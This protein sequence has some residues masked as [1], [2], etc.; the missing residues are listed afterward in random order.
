M[1]ATSHRP[2]RGAAGRA[3]RWLCYRR[4]RGVLL[5]ATSSAVVLTGFSRTSPSSA[6]NVDAAFA[7]HLSPQVDVVSSEV[8]WLDAYRGPIRAR[9]V[10]FVGSTGRPGEE[11]SA[12]SD[13]YYAEVRATSEAAVTGPTVLS[14]SS[15]RNLTRTSG[16]S[17]EQLLRQGRHVAYASK[18]GDTY[19]AVGVLD[20]RGERRTAT[21][22][23]PLRAKIQNALSNL[24]DTG[25]LRGFARTRFALRKPAQQLALETRESTVV[26]RV[27][28]AEV[29]L[30]V[31]SRKSGRPEVKRAQS[32]RFEIRPAHKAQPGTLTWVVDTVRKLSFV[33][34]EPIAWLEHRV[35]ALKDWIDRRWYNVVGTDTEA[36]VAKDFGVSQAETRRRAEFSVPDPEIGWPPPALEPIVKRAAK[37]EGEWIAVVQDPFVASY[38][39]APPAFYQSFLQVD[40]ERPFTRVYVVIWDPRQVQFRVMTGTRE[41][42]SATGETGPGMVPRDKDTMR[43]VVAGFNGGFQSLHGEFG[44]MSEGRVYLPPKPW[45]ATVAVFRDGRVGMGSWMD[46]PE[47]VRRYQEE[48][49]TA[50]IPKN[51]VELRQNLTSVVEGDRYN[52]WRRWWWGAAPAEAEEQAYIDRS[53]VCLTKAGHMAYFWGKSMGADELGSAM[54]AT[55]CVRGVHLDM[56]QRHTGFE[57]YNVGYEAKPLPPLDRRLRATEFD[58]PMPRASSFRVRGRKLVRA[59][60]P[61]RFPRYIRRDPRDFFYLTLKPVLPGPHLGDGRPGAP[62]TFDTSGL[63]HAGWPH[64]FARTHLGEKKGAR[65]WLVRID[66]KRT[67]PSAMMNAESSDEPQGSGEQPSKEPRILAWLSAPESPAADHAVYAVR[68]TVGWRLRVGAP[69]KSAVVIAKGTELSSSS[70]AVAALGVDEDGFLVYAEREADESHTLAERLAQAGV[71]EAIALDTSRLAFVLGADTVGPDAYQRDINPEQAIAFLANDRPAAEVLFPHVKPR[72]YM[73]WYQMQDTRV[74]YHRDEGPYR[75]TKEKR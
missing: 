29:A 74:R 70:D 36:E 39:N 22:G 6:H 49:A 17:E 57:F 24:Q 7:K 20:T 61:M 41:P 1:N 58:I 18:V 50:Q 40:P 55:R 19:D 75:F 26:A 32:R 60:T 27:D 73:H 8:V 12:R 54:L 13:V 37:G 11:H 2:G 69:P 72:P 63:P 3:A 56:N 65:T 67:M 33:G 4:S 68:K 15:L 42:E 14:V 51:M 30:P 43:R 21:R 66:A 35:F 62:G 10:L 28:G 52:P 59:M 64:A 31:G 5:V 46:P 38:P 45:A 16:A 34:P 53:G 44:M 9:P 47:G 48:W 23:W 71:R 25:R